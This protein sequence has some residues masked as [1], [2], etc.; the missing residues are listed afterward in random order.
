M[1]K[2]LALFLILSATRIYADDQKPSIN[3]PT[4]LVIPSGA[5]IFLLSGSCPEGT[6]DVTATHTGRFPRIGI[7]GATG[8]SDSHSHA[9]HAAHTHAYSQIVNHTHTVTVTDPGHNHTQ[10]GHSHSMPVGATDDTSAPFDRADA[11]TNT[12]GANATTNTNSATPAIQGN[13]TGITATTANPAGGVASGTTDN[14]SAT[15]THSTENNIP[16][17]IAMKLCVVN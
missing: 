17:Y 14:P 5:V 7:A 12:G 11:G 13:T 15:L 1:K 8:G 16:S 4:T 9:D 2:L 3:D 10:S 6:S